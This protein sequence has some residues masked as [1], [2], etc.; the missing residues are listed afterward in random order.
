MF[1]WSTFKRD[2]AEQL[3]VVLFVQGLLQIMTDGN[4]GGGEGRIDSGR[5]GTR[6]AGGRE[7]E[8]DGG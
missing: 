1:S 4:K 7:R 6:Q 3:G 2:D 8:K 5:E